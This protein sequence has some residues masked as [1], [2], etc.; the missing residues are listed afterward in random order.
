MDYK[1]LHRVLDQIVSETTIDYDNE[2]VNFP[3]PVLPFS[4]TYP[5]PVHRT[6]FSIFLSS[7]LPFFIFLS[8]FKHCESVYGLNME[9]LEYV[10]KE[11]K[12]IIID[13]IENN[14]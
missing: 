9:E 12:Q 14:G 3:F 6:T 8:F 11:Y 13:K 5:S 4:N 2:G 10:W 7:P 1:F